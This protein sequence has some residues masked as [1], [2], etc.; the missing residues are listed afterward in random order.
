MELNEEVI[1]EANTIK[2]DCIITFHPLI[3]HPLTGIY[4]SDRVGKLVTLL[5]KNDITLISIHTNFDA[6]INGTSRILCEKLELQYQSFLVPDSKLEDFGMGVICTSETALTLDMLLQKVATVCH[7]PIRYCHGKNNTL[8]KTIAI[9]GGSGSS[10][11]D[12]A[13]KAKADAFITAD[14][15]YH[16]FHR[17]KGKMALIDPGHYEMEQFVAKGIHDFLSSKI[18]TNVQ[19]F[20]S[21]VYTNPVRYYPAMNYLE[22]QKNIL[23]NK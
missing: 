19:L 21:K 10:Y 9:V 20:L 3:F 4:D 7:S 12:E 1:E 16:N 11:I 23:N 13:I 17:V 5:I 18:E 15:S 6:Y 2:A 22:M 8:I 14:V